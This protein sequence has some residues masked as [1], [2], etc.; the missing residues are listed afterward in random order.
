MDNYIVCER[1]SNL[2]RI[3]VEICRH[4]CEHAQTCQAFQEYVKAQTTAELAIRPATGDWHGD[5]GVPLPT[6]S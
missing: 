4:R 1:R 2:P 5:K 3:H 6:P